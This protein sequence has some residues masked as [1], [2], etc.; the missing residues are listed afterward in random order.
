VIEKRGM[1]LTDEQ[2]KQLDACTDV[3]L[4][5]AWHDRAVVARETSKVFETK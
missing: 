4:L 1:L 2:A 5:E 3:A